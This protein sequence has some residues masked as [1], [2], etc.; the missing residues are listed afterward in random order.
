MYLNRRLR[1]DKVKKT[2]YIYLNTLTSSADD[3]DSLCNFA[4]N[5]YIL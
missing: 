4:S 5:T 2:G 3:K 1:N